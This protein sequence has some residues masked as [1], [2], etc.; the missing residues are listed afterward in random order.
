MISSTGADSLKPLQI[1]LPCTLALEL[2]VQQGLR[3]MN[4]RFPQ[5]PPRTSIDMPTGS[6][7]ADRCPSVICEQV[8][9]DGLDAGRL[10]VTQGCKLLAPGSRGQLAFVLV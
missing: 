1:V 4:V 7:S 9:I 5:L 10:G 2:I 3:G 8:V 6:D